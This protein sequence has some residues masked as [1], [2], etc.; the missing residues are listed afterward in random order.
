MVQRPPNVRVQFFLGFLMDGPVSG[1]GNK[2][3][4][5]SVAASGF[6]AEIDS[7]IVLCLFHC[8]EGTACLLLSCVFKGW[9][10]EVHS[11]LISS[12][13]T[14]AYPSLSILPLCHLIEQ[15]VTSGLCIDML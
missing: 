10:V 11:P 14:N 2:T 5:S 13:G 15:V 3:G 1:S 6:T 12:M 4:F 9:I 7:P 8:M